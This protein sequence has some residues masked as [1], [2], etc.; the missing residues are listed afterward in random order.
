LYEAGLEQS[1]VLGSF[2]PRGRS[3]VSQAL[4][5]KCDSA[6]Y[7]K[8]LCRYHGAE[9]Q[10]GVG[11]VVG[12]FTIAMTSRRRRHVFGLQTAF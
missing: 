10:A 11:A 9:A 2:D 12:R 7:E 1:D 4:A 8:P 5:W 6:M 3:A